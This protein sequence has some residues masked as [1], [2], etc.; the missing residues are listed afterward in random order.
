[1][2]APHLTGGPGVTSTSH[3]A[4]FKDRLLEE[5]FDQ[6]GYVRVD[7]LD[8]A[9]VARLAESF[10]SL[11]HPISSAFHATMSSPEAAY[12]RQVRE[13]IAAVIG[14]LVARNFNGYRLCVANF[15]YKAPLAPDSEVPLHLDWSFVDEDFHRSIHLWCPLVDTN[16]ENGCLAVFPGTQ[17]LAHR[18][19]AHSDPHPFA[20]VESELRRRNMREEPVMA[21]EALFYDGALLHGSRPNRS[22]RPRLCIG[23]VLVPVEAAVIHCVRVSP[24]EVERFAVDDDFFL[25]H[26]SG[27]R[28]EGYPTLGITPSELRQVS[29]VEVGSLLDATPADGGEARLG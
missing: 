7:L 24:G 18:A 15:L 13:R 23:C 16:A 26:T 12:R 8:G 20:A 11:E 21:G 25:S 22:S 28:P 4:K 10:A 1:M 27:A 17:L 29:L 2:T 19:R 5:R 9:S 6:E 3:N 14:P